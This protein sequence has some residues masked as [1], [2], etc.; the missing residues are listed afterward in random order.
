MGGVLGSPG[1]T[2]QPKVLLCSAKGLDLA[3]D[4]EV[5]DPPYSWISSSQL[6]NTDS[7]GPGTI[8]LPHY[9]SVNLRF[10][11]LRLFYEGHT[12]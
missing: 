8:Y 4:L 11:H 3:Q 5:A 7:Q 10:I 2:A 12:G 9:D 1:V 6:P